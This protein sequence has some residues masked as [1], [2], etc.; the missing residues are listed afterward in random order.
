MGADHAAESCRVG[1]P[2]LSVVEETDLIGESCCIR[3]AKKTPT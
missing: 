1:A 2:T 3:S